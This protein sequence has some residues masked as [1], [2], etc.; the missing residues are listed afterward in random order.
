MSRRRPAIRCAPGTAERVTQAAVGVLLA[1]FALDSLAQPV[2]A[3]AAALGAAL[4]IV[5]A[6]RG[7]CPGGLLAQRAAAAAHEPAEE[8]PPR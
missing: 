8:P 7:W 4:L 2:L 1:A 5:G 3:V 6:I